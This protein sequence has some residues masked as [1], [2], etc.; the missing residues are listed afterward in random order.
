M[1]ISKSSKVTLQRKPNNSFLYFRKFRVKPVTSELYRIR[2]FIRDFGHLIGCNDEKLSKIELVVDEI[3]S[4]II[5]YSYRNFQNDSLR[6]LIWVECEGN[7]KLMVVR[8]MDRGEPF[9]LVEY[10][11][12]TIEDNLKHP[13]KGGWGI[14][15]VKALADKIEIS[16][17]DGTPGKNIVE[18]HFKL[19]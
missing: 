15:I 9:N 7:N 16:R 5:Q 3:C 13:Q 1:M 4:N 14:P 12:P 11:A 17:I 2:Q 10:N 18:L 19:E 6:K 8:I